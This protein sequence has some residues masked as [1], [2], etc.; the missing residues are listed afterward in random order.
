MV[1]SEVC[2]DGI[3]C[4]SEKFCEDIFIRDAHDSSAPGNPSP[5]LNSFNDKLRPSVV[6]PFSWEG[7]KSAARRRPQ[8]S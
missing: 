6:S 8:S 5:S 7:L 2:R 4:G 3:V 1:E